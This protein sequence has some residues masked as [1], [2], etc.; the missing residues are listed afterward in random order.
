MKRFLDIPENRIFLAPMAGV[1]DSSFRRI[2]REYG[3]GLVYSEM[4]SAKGIH[5]GDKKTARLMNIH[6]SEM[7]A[8][9]QLF[10]SDPEIIAEAALSAERTGAEFIDINMGCPAPKIV[11]NGDG[12]ALMKDPALAERIIRAAAE[13]CGLPVTVKIRKGWDKNSENALL[14]AKIAEEN[15]AAA[16]CV[17]GRTRAEFYG[18]KADWDI[19]RTVKS[20]V[21]IPV[22]G[23]GDIFSAEDAADMFDYT[24][25]DAVMVARGC[26]GNPFIFRQINE[27]IR[28]GYVTYDPGPEERIAAA[29]RHINMICE[30]KGEICGV[31][32]SRK[33]TAWYIKGMRGASR[34][35]EIVFKITKKDELTDALENYIKK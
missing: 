21:K 9:I 15:G 27:Y 17:H 4:I 28:D 12:S 31:K 3:A 16:I 24:G 30:E 22:I 5:Y 26:L 35:K 33:H 7:P 13:A 2:C 18:G 19:I 10:G 34:L 25:C 1:T 6:K 8:G 14:L 20:E 23:N 29:I 32:E 11:N